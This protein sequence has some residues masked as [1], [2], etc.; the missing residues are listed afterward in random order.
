MSTT[1]RTPLTEQERKAFTTAY[2]F[3]E[4]WHNIAGQAE[5]WE[6]LARSLYDLPADMQNDELCQR[7]INAVIEFLSDRQKRAEEQTRMEI[8]GKPVN[9]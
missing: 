7:L 5:E 1:S 4:Q 6:A 8:D 9:Y 3:F 2:R